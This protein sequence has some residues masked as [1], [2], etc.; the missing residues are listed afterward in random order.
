MFQ[1]LLTQPLYNGFIALIGIMPGGDVGL[2]IIVLTFIIRFLFYPIFASQIRT[3]MGMQ[4]M[5]GELEELKEKYKNDVAEQ[6]KQVMG[7][8]K[9]YKVNPLSL[10]LSLFIQLPI[11]FALYYT[12]FHTKLPEI[13][14]SLL[15]PFVHAPQTVNVHF[16]HLL[17]LTM[18]NN[19]LLV[20]VVAA[21]QFLVMYLTLARTNKHSPKNLSEEKRLAMKM[22]QNVSLYML[23]AI[24]A[25]VAYTT[26][27]AVGLYFAAGSV[28]SI[29]QEWLIRRQLAAKALKDASH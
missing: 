15:Y 29:G 26:P 6:N 27:A 9:K 28:V 2:A 10:I 20:I 14:L 18:A 11:F 17:D 23:P 16:L 7:L 8:Y 22:Q 1:T 13:N 5:Q 25:M 4:A 24:I 3:T 19:I 12:F 21:L